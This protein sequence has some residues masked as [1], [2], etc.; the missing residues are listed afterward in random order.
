MCVEEKGKANYGIS[1]ARYGKSNDPTNGLI[2]RNVHVVFPGVLGPLDILRRR[3]HRWTT[4]Q[5]RVALP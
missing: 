5:D 1:P 4:E 2:K 3:V